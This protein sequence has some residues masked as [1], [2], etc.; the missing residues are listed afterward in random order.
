MLWSSGTRDSIGLKDLTES[1]FRI[2]S[3]LDHPI[4]APRGHSAVA[5]LAVGSAQEVAAWPRF[6]R[7]IFYNKV[8]PVLFWQGGDVS[9]GRGISEM[10]FCWPIC[11]T[12]LISATCKSILNGIDHDLA[13]PNSSKFLALTVRSCMWHP[14]SR[15]GSHSVHGISKVAVSGPMEG[16]AHIRNSPLRP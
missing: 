1:G 9:G 15:S 10:R 3:R 7:L 14:A 13:A 4:A 5:Q 6:W 11:A 2:G 8:N 12:W 16:C